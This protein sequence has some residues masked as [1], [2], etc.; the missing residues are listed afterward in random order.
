MKK[1]ILILLIFYFFLDFSFLPTINKSYLGGACLLTSFLILLLTERTFL[2]NIFWIILTAFFINIISP[3][4]FSVYLIIWLMIIG[5]IYFI[6]MIFIDENLN[7]FK[8]NII[9]ILAFLF[10]KILLNFSYS[11]LTK[12]ITLQNIFNFQGL[13]WQG[14]IIKFIVVIISYNIVYKIF[15]KLANTIFKNKLNLY[16]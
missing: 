14:L 13:S 12:D 2:E 11:F 10:Y 8:R 4:Y 15:S 9:F 1:V 3:F 6:K 16:K 5:I 7:I